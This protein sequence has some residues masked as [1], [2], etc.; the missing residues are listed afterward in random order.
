MRLDSRHRCPWRHAANHP[1]KRSRPLKLS[2]AGLR[3]L[4]A[5]DL[6]GPLNSRHPSY[7]TQV[8]TAPSPPI[9]PSPPAGS[10]SCRLSSQPSADPSR[11]PLPPA[12]PS[13]SP[14]PRTTEDDGDHLHPHAPGEGCGGVL[15]KAAVPTHVYPDPGYSPPGRVATSLPSRSC[16]ID[17]R[18]SMG[19]VGRLP[20]AVSV[21]TK[22]RGRRQFFRPGDV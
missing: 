18:P 17:Q 7:A 8:P 14:H 20:C 16:C 22:S 13:A 2:V 9:S 19:R 1:T 5:H 3:R 11:D 15:H 4:S 10:S 21:V 12:L 6:C